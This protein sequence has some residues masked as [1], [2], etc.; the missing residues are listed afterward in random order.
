MRPSQIYKRSLQE[1]AFSYS[2]KLLYLLLGSHAKLTGGT[3]I[4]RMIE[5]KVG[6][7]VGRAKR[8]G[9]LREAK[10]DH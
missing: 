1:L 7:S 4:N 5:I 10:R 3:V 9:S 2:Q 6:H 8:Y